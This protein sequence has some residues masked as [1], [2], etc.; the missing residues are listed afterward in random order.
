MV[1]AWLCGKALGMMLLGDD[2]NLLTGGEAVDLSW[3][4]EQMLITEERATKVAHAFSVP[5]VSPH[6]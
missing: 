5:D 3:F 2:N 1:L 6:L 4:P